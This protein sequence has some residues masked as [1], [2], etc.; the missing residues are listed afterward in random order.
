MFEEF[1]SWVC[2]WK[3]ICVKELKERIIVNGLLLC[4]IGKDHCTEKI[5]VQMIKSI[6][7]KK[8]QRKIRIYYLHIDFGRFFMKKKRYRI[9]GILF[10][11]ILGVV[12]VNTSGIKAAELDGSILEQIDG[13][14]NSDGISS[15]F[16]ARKT[17]K[18]K[19]N[20]QTAFFIPN[21]LEGTLTPCR[22]GIVIAFLNRGID[23]IDT[24][25]FTLSIYNYIGGLVATKKL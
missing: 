20:A 18:E 7:M 24:V 10:S 23:K 16:V 9:W 3:G 1:F 2:G 15:T 13:E 12:S 11:L 19:S 22:S 6:L 14:E 8:L 25:S 5:N 21:I 4:Y 17:G